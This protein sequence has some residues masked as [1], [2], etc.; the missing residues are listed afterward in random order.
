M[1]PVRRCT[2][3]AKIPRAGA[4]DF[5]CGLTP[6]K[7]LNIQPGLAG[8]REKMNLPEWMISIERLIQGSKLGRTRL[9]TMQANVGVMA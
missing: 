1:T 2:S 4:R 9:A 6:A 7:R 5:G 8:F 3:S